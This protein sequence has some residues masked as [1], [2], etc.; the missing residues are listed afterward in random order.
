MLL[1]CGDDGS[2]R[3]WDLSHPA[4]KATVLKEPSPCV[5]DMWASFVISGSDKGTV[6]I[7]DLAA[8]NDD[9][10]R[11]ELNV[12]VFSV[13][14]EETWVAFGGADGLLKA[15]NPD[16][17]P[18]QKIELLGHTEDVYFVIFVSDKL[19]SCCNETF[20]VWDLENFEQE[21]RTLQDAA[22]IDSFAAENSLL[23]TFGS[24]SSIRV[25]NFNNLEAGCMF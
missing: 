19:V 20:E 15:W 6:K 23:A 7:W 18:S 3:I 8:L 9:P 11:F 12:E 13:P 10:I 2:I 22:G 4:A 21:S 1:P 16:T 25:W 17:E 5:A 14:T 24:D